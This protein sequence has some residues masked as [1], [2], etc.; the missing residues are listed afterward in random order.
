MKI[1]S[2]VLRSVQL[3]QLDCMIQLDRVCRE[4]G[5]T[6]Y[7]IEGTLL[8]AIRHKGFISSVLH[9]NQKKY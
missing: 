7:L 1:S 6:Y 2:K 9:K 4:R 5:L 3:C 8:G